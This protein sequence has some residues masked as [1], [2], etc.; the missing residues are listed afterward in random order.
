MN[1]KAQD[2]KSKIFSA[3]PKKGQEEMVGFALI[4][5][6]VAIIFI[7][8]LVSYIK[9]SSQSEELENQEA[10]SFVQAFLQCT[11][12]CESED[13]SNLTLQSLIFACQEGG[14]CS[15][16][17]NPCKVLNDTI[18]YAIKESWDV[19]ENSSIKGYS[20]LIF[21]EEE[22]ILNITEG[23]VTNNYK[24]AEQDF[25]KGTKSVTILFDAYS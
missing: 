11:T 2:P 8:L 18:K 17:M 21:S 22:Q 20:L 19:G 9:N 16:D 12:I 3:N 24:G 5:I 1:K 25:A 6:L 10:N 13:A 23:V 4:I 14:S 7:V 15:Y